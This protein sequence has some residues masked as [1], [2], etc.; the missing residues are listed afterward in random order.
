M[1]VESL[2]LVWHPCIT[3]SA[4][5]RHLASQS[6]HTIEWMSTAHSGACKQNHEVLKHK[7]RLQNITGNRRRCRI[8]CDTKSSSSSSSSGHR[9]RC[10]RR[11]SCSWS[12]TGTGSGSSS[13]SMI[14]QVK[15]CP[16]SC[17]SVLR[18]SCRHIQFEAMLYLLPL[19]IFRSCLARQSRHVCASSQNSSESNRTPKISFGTRTGESHHSGHTC[20]P[21]K[22]IH[23]L[24][25]TRRTCIPK[26]RTL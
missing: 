4:Q 14:G 9:C 12:D 19:Y 20:H 22:L 5:R 26:E 23:Q 18:L 1:C 17:W 13:S 10:I 11:R 8:M 25:S 2:V 6:K 16:H 7:W 15:T 3:K 21:C 24:F